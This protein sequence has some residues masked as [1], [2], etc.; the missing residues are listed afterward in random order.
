M[1]R[2]LYWSLF[3]FAVIVLAFFGI[4][5]YLL[6]EQ[7]FG[8]QNYLWAFLFLVPGVMV[9][10]Y[11]FLSLVLEKQQRH[12]EQLEHLVREVLHEINL[13]IATID[14]NL[15][16]IVRRARDEKLLRRL[17][18]I[19]AAARRL[20][21]LYRDLAYEIRREIAPVER[22]RFD[23]AELLNERIEFFRE[24]G[25]NPIE[26]DLEPTPVVADR[27]GMEQVV[28]NLLENAMKYSPVERPVQVTLKEGQLTI[29]DRGIGMDENELLRIYERY[30][31][32]DRQVRG[33]GIGLALVK[34][35]CDDEGI[36]L[37][38]RSKK[39]EGTTV[40]MELG[41]IRE[42]GKSR[43]GR[44]SMKRVSPTKEG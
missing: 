33:E 32:S 8:P 25:R 4:H 15:E 10:G 3:V 18:R 44:E 16:M 6:S 2:E 27:I 20:K 11:I 28:D 38:I 43:A 24:L 21:R 7:G 35:Y 34:R 41:K 14:A 17:D 37:R 26:V 5:Y 30:Y 23:L 42:P 31:Q 19:G 9:V 1:K 39:G 13:P 40:L 36:K 29:R 12:E 22:Q